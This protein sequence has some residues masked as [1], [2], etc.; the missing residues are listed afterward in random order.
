MEWI[1]IKPSAPR[2][3]PHPCEPSPPLPVLPACA[4]D[5]GISSQPTCKAISS[6]TRSCTVMPLPVMPP[7]APTAVPVSAALKSRFT[8]WRKLAGAGSV[9]SSRGFLTL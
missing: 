6:K 4:C 5:V 7:S 1:T 8:V 9:H 3:D 2:C